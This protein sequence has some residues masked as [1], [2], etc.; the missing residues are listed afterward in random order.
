MKATC[1]TALVS[2]FFNVTS[3]Y[4]VQR[5]DGPYRG[6]GEQKTTTPLSLQ[7]TGGP[8]TMQ[9]PGYLLPL[10]EWP[11]AAQRCHTSLQVL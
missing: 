8:N 3:R 7:P 11:N 5:Y 9:P 10:V 2:K 6:I 4:W 1:L